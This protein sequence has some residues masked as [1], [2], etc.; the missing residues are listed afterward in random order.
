MDYMATSG[1]LSFAANQGVATFSVPITNDAVTEFNETVNLTLSSPTGAVLDYPDTTMLIIRDN[2]PAQLR[3]SGPSYTVNEFTNS[4]FIAVITVYR[5]GNTSAA[6]TVQYATSNGTALAGSDYTTT[7]GTLS[8]AAN[9]N[10]LTFNVL[11]LDDRAVEP[12]E[13]VRLTLSAP[14]G[15]TLAAPSAATLTVISND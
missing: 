7:S 12:N 5:Q 8:F 10:L 4:I 11:I 2:E 9:Q 1:T 14:S 13:T 6:A 15:G 3:F